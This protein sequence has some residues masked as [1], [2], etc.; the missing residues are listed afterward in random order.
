[1]TAVG[2]LG[3]VASGWRVGDLPEW[4]LGFVYL[5]A[6]AALVA[7]SIIT[8]PMGARLAHRL[9]VATL[10]RIFAV[11]MFVLASRMVVSYW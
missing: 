8:A 1:M 3:Y 9:P 11:L 2:T 6:L 5:P 7:G 10:K 4:H